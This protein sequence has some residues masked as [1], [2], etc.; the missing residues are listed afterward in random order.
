MFLVSTWSRFAQSIEARYL[1]ENEI[2]VGAAPTGDA[3]ITSEWSTILHPDKV[4]RTLDVDGCS[5]WWL[6][7]V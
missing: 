1:I 5:S 2:V 7:L 3:P 6:S 4:H